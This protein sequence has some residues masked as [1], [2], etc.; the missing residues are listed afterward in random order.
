[1]E[2]IPP[3]DH[4]KPKQFLGFL[5]SGDHVK[6]ALTAVA[7]T[8][9]QIDSILWLLNYGRAQRLS[10]VTALA[11]RLNVSG[12]TLSRVFAGKYGA[13]LA[14]IVADIDHFR[15]LH[16]ERAGFGD[17]IVCEDLNV[18]KDI[19]DFC[20]LTR[21]S[22]TIAILW[23][24]NQ[25]GKTWALEKIYAPKNNHGRTI[26]VRMPVGGG[27]RL[28][29]EEILR[30][31]GIS[32]RKSYSEM[33]Q[34]VLRYF[35]PQTLLII[36]EFHQAMI[37]RTLRTTT[38][39]TVRE[40]HDLTGC[41]VVICG[42]DVLPDMIS[43]PRFVKLLGQTDNRGVLRRRVPPTPYREDVQALCKAYGF[44]DPHGEARKLVQ[45]IASTNGIGKLCK[46]FMMSK[47]LASKRR[48]PVTWQHFLDTHAT[49]KSW[50]RG[51]QMKREE[52]AK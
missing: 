34:R 31:C 9:E 50:E 52:A 1:M 3:N 47:R 8:T 27:T 7:A 46:F 33:K 44:G 11:E 2:N 25:S 18:V 5:P 30:A 45:E 22:Q 26:F 10:S 24:P 17:R 29:L 36:D 15:A 39:E 49:L 41:G 42:T 32:E 28:F 21:A 6:Q 37:G 13:G 38:V 12:S 14:S 20:D 16:A 35:D 51:E 19:A 48:Q 4:G 23:G 40:I 43:N